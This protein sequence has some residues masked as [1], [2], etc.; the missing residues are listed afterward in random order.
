MM[1]GERGGEEGFR[2]VYTLFVPYGFG[3][4]SENCF[5]GG[6]S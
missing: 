5:R 1:I 2:N 6:C 3:V 4:G